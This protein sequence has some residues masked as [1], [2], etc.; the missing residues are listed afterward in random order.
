MPKPMPVTDVVRFSVTVTAYNHEDRWLAQTVETG[1]ITFGTTREE[2]EALNARANVKLVR[3]WKRH[4]KAIL[5]GFMRKHGIKYGIAEN[6]EATA[7]AV[8]GQ[9]LA[10]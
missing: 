1:L 8:E 4:G 2:A 10:A 6:P 7:A 5:D 9:L 3:G